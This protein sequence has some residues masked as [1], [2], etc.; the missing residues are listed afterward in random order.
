MI[1]L[2]R[3]FAEDMLASKIPFEAQKRM[4]QL[5]LETLISKGFNWHD[6]LIFHEDTALVTEFHL[7]NGGVWLSMDSSSRFSLL[8]QNDKKEP[9]KYH[10]HNARYSSHSYALMALVDRWVEY[11]DLLKGK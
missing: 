4:N 7:G 1:L 2:D 11:A 6:P 9:L 10:S 8:N 5:S 3:D